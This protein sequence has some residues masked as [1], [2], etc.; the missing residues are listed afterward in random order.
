VV[1]G[2]VLV[3]VDCVLG[4]DHPLFY[5]SIFYAIALRIR[6]LEKADVEGLCTIIEVFFS[7]NDKNTTQQL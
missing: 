3:T 6:M 1:D 2:K 5:M 7:G 4:E